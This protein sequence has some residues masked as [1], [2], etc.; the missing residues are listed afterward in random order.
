LWDDK[1]REVGRGKYARAYKS[2]KIDVWRIAG[3]MPKTSTPSTK[4]ARM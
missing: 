1:S 2:R 4:N 3:S